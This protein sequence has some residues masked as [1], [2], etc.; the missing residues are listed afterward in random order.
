MVLCIS[1][2]LPPTSGFGGPAVSFSK[3]L[4]FLESQ[5]IIV[6]ALSATSEAS[7]SVNQKTTR[8]HYYLARFGLKYG[9]SVPLIVSVWLKSRKHDVLIINGLTNPPLL[10]GTLAGLF[11]NKKI[12]LFTRGGLEKQRTQEW[13]FLKRMY[14]NFHLK[15]LRCLDYRSNL[16]IAF[17]SA[18]ER[19]RSENISKNT[20]ICSNYQ[21]EHIRNVKKSFKRLHICYVGRH[22]VEK[23]ADRLEE[24]LEY[25]SNS[26][27]NVNF[28][29]T[30]MI[31]S[32]RKIESLEKYRRN[33]W[34]TVIYNGTSVDVENLLS[35]ANILFF[36]SRTENYGNALVEAVSNGLVPCITDETHWKVM[37]DENAAISIYE[38]KVILSGSNWDVSSLEKKAL[39]A[40]K[41]LFQKFI[42]G[43]GYDQLLPIITCRPE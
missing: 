5:E 30:L 4:D 22:S 23:G 1:T 19:S 41:I 37:L 32:N 39:R 27:S 40:Q 12:I 43:F 26:R 3:F 42:K 14:Y 29:V 2:H 6:E 13:H 20:F 17:Q 16:C 8:K 34:L 21:E 9:L 28:Q 15:L 36:P 38:L 10:V 25:L 24:L 35:E 11:Y 18:D 31:A 33:P 7:Y